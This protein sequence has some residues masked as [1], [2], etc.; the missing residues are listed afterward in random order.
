MSDPI[1]FALASLG[2]LAMPGP[3]NT[4]LATSGAAAGFRR[5]LP[6][7]GAG[8]L[9]YLISIL[10][11][12]LAVAPI[13]NGAQGAERVLQA[14]CAAYLLYAAWKLWR[15]RAE[16]IAAPESFRRVL[17][18]TALNPKALVFAFVILPFLR[19]GAVVAA[20]PYVAAFLVMVAL[21]GAAWIAIGAIFHAN[22]AGVWARGAGAVVL[23]LFAFL[24]LASAAR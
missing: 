11:L 22:G 2:L 21:T 19:D 5:S 15:T 18:A 8:M 7:V 6:L 20:A 16:A 9:G 4:L 23:C 17:I 10:T 14:A 12:T 3:T 1:L 24:L 13:T